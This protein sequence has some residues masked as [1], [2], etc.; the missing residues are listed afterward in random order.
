MI[1]DGTIELFIHVFVVGVGKHYIGPVGRSTRVPVGQFLKK[2]PT[3]W[4][5]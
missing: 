2:L 3:S 1:P 5:S 4:V